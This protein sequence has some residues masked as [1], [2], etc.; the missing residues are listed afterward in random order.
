MQRTPVKV[1]SNETPAEQAAKRKF[2]ET[3]PDFVE[4]SPNLSVGSM[5]ANELMAIM[6]NSMASLLDDRLEN[7]ATKQDIHYVKNRVDS[8]TDKINLLVA[9]NDTLKAEIKNL[10]DEKSEDRRRILFLENQIKR[11]NL[12]FKGVP[13]N[14]P[15]IVAIKSIIDTKLNINI[16]IEIVATHKIFEKNRKMA[17]VVEFRSEQMA[18]EIVRNKKQLVGSAIFIEYDLNSERQEKKKLMLQLKNNILQ[19][20]KT[21]RITVF[22]DKLMI[23]NKSFV[24]GRQKQLMCENRKAEEMLREI[25][26][27]ELNLNLKYD[28]I[29]AATK[30][31]N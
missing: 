12:I 11:K 17:V 13:T 9:E 6:K 28:D 29:L 25:Y 19:L 23:D 2:L 15:P 31:K 26:G 8:L 30:S 10:K 27:T 1:N 20:N 24:W 7:L 22:D 14:S 21:K 16:P 5:S 18:Q 4:S 3:S